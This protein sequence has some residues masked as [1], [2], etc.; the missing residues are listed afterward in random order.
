MHLTVFEEVAKHKLRAV[1]TL[2]SCIGFACIGLQAGVIGPSLLDLAVLVQCRFDQITYMVTGR[3]VGY[4]IGS[5][6]AG[7]IA[8]RT[9]PQ[10][11]LCLTL[12]ISALFH[13]AMPLAGTLNLLLSLITLTGIVNGITDTS[14]LLPESYCV[15]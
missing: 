7:L 3:S 8:S 9:N 13:F 12:L 1:K 6:T 2:L 5:I 10:L 11:V 4:A 15:N 14:K